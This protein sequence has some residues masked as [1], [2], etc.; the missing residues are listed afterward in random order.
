[1]WDLTLPFVGLS[2]LSPPAGNKQ[3]GTI[4]VSQQRST[5]LNTLS[6]NVKSLATLTFTADSFFLALST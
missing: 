1:M 3:F 2:T 5:S 6:R 4:P